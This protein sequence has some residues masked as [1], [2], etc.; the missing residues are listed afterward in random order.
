MRKNVS[1][2]LLVYT[3]NFLLFLS[4]NQSNTHAN[5]HAHTQSISLFSSDYDGYQLNSPQFWFFSFFLGLVFFSVKGFS[6]G[7]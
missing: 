5:A 3:H 4:L 2:E 1:K 7:I 6:R